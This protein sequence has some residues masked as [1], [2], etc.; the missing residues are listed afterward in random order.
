MRFVLSSVFG[1]GVAS[2]CLCAVE[3]AGARPVITVPHTVDTPRLR[4][5]ADDPAWRV[6]EAG[7]TLGRLGDAAPSGGDDAFATKTEILWDAQFLYVRFWC[8][9][10][11]MPWAPHGDRR[12]A[13]H[14]E[15][16]AVELFIDP[17]GDARQ[18]V[19]VQVSPAGGVFD[20]LYLLTARPRSNAA[21]VLLDE[22]LRRDQW[23]FSE[24]NWEGL[25]AASS[26][27][28]VDGTTVGWIT[29]VALPAKPLLRRLN[30]SAYAAPLTMRAHLVRIARPVDKAD[31]SG[32]AFF[33]FSWTVFP[34]G[35]PHRTPVLMGEL[36]LVP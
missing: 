18:F 2:V 11:E 29:D 1:L 32:R 36:R 26:P 3:N 6:P 35:R 15:G 13:P 17:V 27:W 16:D 31:A 20:K 28:T 25:R 5:E 14:H 33:S 21:G 23:E 12:D 10:P 34:P 8:R 30:H 24:W 9:A 4:A 7:A 19:E 22:L